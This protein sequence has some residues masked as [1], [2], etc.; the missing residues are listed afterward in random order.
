MSTF[1]QRR[2]FLQSVALSVASILLHPMLH[3]FRR[4]TSREEDAFISH[5]TSVYRHRESAEIIGWQY[6]QST[7][8][9]KNVETLIDLVC[10]T[11]SLGRREFLDM[12]KDR[13]RAVF[14][15]QQRDD[16]A[17]NRTVKVQGWILSETEVRLCALAAL[18]ASSSRATKLRTHVLT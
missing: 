8:T 2:F 6:L 5:L 13:L 7:A 3:A 10:S 12:D 18:T 16:F 11:Q 14:A 17:N 4:L 15:S 9:E 1:I